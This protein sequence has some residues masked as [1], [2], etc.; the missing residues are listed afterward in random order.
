MGAFDFQRSG[1]PQYLGAFKTERAAALAY[2]AFMR[3]EYGKFASFNF[4]KANERPPE[5]PFEVTGLV[6][7][8]TSKFVGRRCR[9]FRFVGV[10][11]YGNGKKWCWRAQLNGMYATRYGFRSELSAAR[12]REL[13]I[14]KQRWP[15]R[16]NFGKGARSVVK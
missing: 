8:P 7:N 10:R 11:P 2:D 15:N 4:P 14:R 16:P 5:S 9:G 12:S 13:H 3:R 1:R 6:P